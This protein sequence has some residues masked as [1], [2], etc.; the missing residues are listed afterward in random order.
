ML[1]RNSAPAPRAFCFTGI[2]NRVGPRRNRFTAIQNITLNT[3]ASNGRIEGLIAEPG[4]G[5]RIAVPPPRMFEVKKSDPIEIVLAKDSNGQFLL[6]K[7][8]QKQLHKRRYRSRLQFADDLQDL[9][10]K[11]R[12]QLLTPSQ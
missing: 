12:A 1:R 7:N 2:W 5:L 3:I 10:E 6:D 8:G 9:D 4:P 11:L